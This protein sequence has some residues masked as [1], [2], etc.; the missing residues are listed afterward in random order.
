MKTIEK[1][2]YL[3]ALLLIAL[4]INENLVQWALAVNVGGHSIIEGFN[5]AFKYFSVSS[6][7]LSAGFRFIPYIGLAIIL[8]VLS[9]TQLKDFVPPVFAG[10]LAGILGM[11]LWGLWMAQRPYYIDE[12]VSSTTAIAFLFI[13]FYAVATGLLGIILAAMI[14]TPIRYDMNAGKN[15]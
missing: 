2:W 1:Y 14:Y 6:Y 15:R 9:K 8:I 12:H 13:P 10:G 3:V 5:D 11:I 4:I 7:F